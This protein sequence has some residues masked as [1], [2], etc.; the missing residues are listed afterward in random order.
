MFT[1]TKKS[2]FCLMLWNILLIFAIIKTVYDVYW[3]L[4]SL[5][6]G[7]TTMTVLVENRS[8][9]PYTYNGPTFTVGDWCVK[10]LLI[11]IHCFFYFY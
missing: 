11:C 4:L 10:G 5:P 6:I 3:L 2:S 8:K 1:K 9:H 7:M